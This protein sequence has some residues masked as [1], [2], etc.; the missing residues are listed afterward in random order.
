MLNINYKICVKI[1]FNVH[2][3][4]KKITDNGLSFYILH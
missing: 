2:F 3:M 4:L 1:Y